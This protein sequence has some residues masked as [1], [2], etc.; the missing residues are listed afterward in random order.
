MKIFLGNGSD[1]CIDLLIRAFC[2]PKQDKIM[3]CP[4][5]FS[6]YEHSAHSQHIE[7]IEV[8]LK[9]ETFQLD[10]N[11]IKEKLNDVKIIFLCS[12]NNP[13]GNLFNEKD[14]EEIVKSFNGLVLVDEAYI[15]FANSDSWVKKLKNI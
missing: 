3:I 10:V 11:A 12:P 15:D 1:E 4:P 13:T 9:P 7:V 5:V 14:I 6:M 2:E 8:L